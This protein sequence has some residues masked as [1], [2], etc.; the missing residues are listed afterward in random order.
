MMH[1]GVTGR[2]WR[3]RCRVLGFESLGRR[4]LFSLAFITLLVSSVVHAGA[5]VSITNR[6]DRDHKVTLIEGE[7]KVDHVLKRDQTLQDVCPKGCVLRLNDVDDDEYQL[8][9]GDVVSIEEGFLYYDA[10]EE[11][12]A[13]PGQQGTPEQKKQ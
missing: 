3:Q 4:S 10:P 9:P 1:S 12:P 8:E 11:Q 5:S 6:D 13:Q 7:Q 2:T